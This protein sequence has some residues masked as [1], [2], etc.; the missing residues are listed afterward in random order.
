MSLGRVESLVHS[1]PAPAKLKP[2]PKKLALNQEKVALG[3]AESQDGLFC[4]W[5]KR[6]LGLHVL[7]DNH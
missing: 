7:L 5:H 3:L 6:S 1:R 4:P 2:A